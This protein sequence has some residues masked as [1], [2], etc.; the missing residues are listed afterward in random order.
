MIDFV[1]C[2]RFTTRTRKTWSA[3]RAPMISSGQGRFD[4]RRLG[5]HVDMYVAW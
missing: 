3:W 5:G 2:V 1:C 4:S